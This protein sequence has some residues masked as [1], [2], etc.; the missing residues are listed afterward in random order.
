MSGNKATLTVPN[1]KQDP[2]GEVLQYLWIFDEE[3]EQ[4][5]AIQEF[6]ETDA[7]PKLTASIPAGSII[8][9]YAYFRKGGLWLGEGANN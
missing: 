9:P 5:L 8:N 4:V 2:D 7:A 6:T 3:S 1:H